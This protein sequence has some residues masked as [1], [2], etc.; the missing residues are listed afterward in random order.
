VDPV[1]NKSAQHK[2]KWLNHVSRME[3]IGY[4]KEILD[5]RP[6]G[7]RRPEWPLKSLLDGYS[8]E[9]ETGHLLA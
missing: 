3:D 6:I 4:P 7:R 2:Q 9:V 5:C 8:R 1:E